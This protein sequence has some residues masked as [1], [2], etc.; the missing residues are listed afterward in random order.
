MDDDGT[1]RITLKKTLS[2]ASS[3]CQKLAHCGCKKGAAVVVNVENQVSRALRRV[4]VVVTGNL[5]VFF[6]K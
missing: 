5:Q 3:C 2:E 4:H 1:K 6:A